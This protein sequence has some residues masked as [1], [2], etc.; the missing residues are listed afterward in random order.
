MLFRKAN[1]AVPMV[2]CVCAL[3]FGCCFQAAAQQP[4]KVAEIAI[5]GNQNISDEA[6]TAV[7]TNL[8]PAG[9]F[10]QDA[11]EKDR[12]LIDKLGY[13]S[14]VTAR[15]EDAPAGVKV[16]FDVVEFPIVKEIRI[17]GN[18][19]ISTERLLSLMRI[20]QGQVYNEQTISLDISAIEKE[21]QGLGF[22]APVSED[23]GID[24]QTGVLTIP[25][26]ES[27]VESID[28]VGNKKTDDRIFLR[29]MRTKPGQVLNQKILFDDLNRRVY[30]LGILDRA[31]WQ[32]PKIS[33]GSEPGKVA[34]VIPVTEQKT[35][36]VMM[37]LGYSSRQKLVGR[38]EVS[39]SNFR[40][41]AEKLDA[42]VEVGQSVGATAPGG[43]SYQLSYYEP[44]L[45]S[46]N[47]SM[48]I[49][50][51]NKLIYRFS[52]SVPFTGGTTISD[53]IYNE[54]HKGITLGFG[55]PLDTHTRITSNLRFEEVGVSLP[56]SLA[57]DTFLSKISQPG[58]IRS[59]TVGGVSNTRDDDADPASGWFRSMSLEVGWARKSAFS[60]IDTAIRPDP[61]DPEAVVPPNTVWTLRTADTGFFEKVQFDIRRYLSKGG[62]KK[63]LDEKRKTIA[64]RL[65]G[66]ISSG[67]LLFGEQFFVGGAETLRGYR[68]DR[69]WGKNML[70]LNAEYRHP[71]GKTLTGVFFTDVGDAWGPVDNIQPN[72]AIASDPRDL[73]QH[74][75]FTPNVGVG[76]GIRVITP[77][78][79]L[80]LDYGVGSEGGRTHF[81]I[82]H[83]F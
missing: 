6:I 50:L 5:T 52:N 49:S 82:G 71:M 19:S 66:G 34:I 25:I 58:P 70:A 81:A 32:A 63:N 29:E 74:N 36:Q 35:G 59:V 11:M 27:I 47:T 23:A 20:K 13:F 31:A 21:Y 22:F 18:K 83:A 45:D 78:G 73:D 57:P 64:L 24:P 1:A 4:P 15:S 56:S 44:W 60:G 16:T 2:L 9:D 53:R 12:Q 48:N 77:I 75:S 76:L 41:R 65:T 61:D 69:F 30:G 55:R 42:L 14:S 7:I 68:E 72:P 38:V 28:F 8:K 62:I 54:R 10:T 40:G 80:R 3:I 26:L 17:L 46:K 67:T 33:P 43:G 79:P 51:Y 39:Q 37:S